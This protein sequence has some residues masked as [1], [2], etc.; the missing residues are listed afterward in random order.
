MSKHEPATLG[1]FEQLVLFAVLRLGPEGYGA[2]IQREIEQCAGRAVSLN[3]VYT[4]VDRLEAKRLV[5]TRMGEP[6]PERGGRRRKH[7]VLLPAGEAALRQ[8]YRTFKLLTEGFE[9]QLQ[10]R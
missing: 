4:T 5:R 2:S 10:G 9:R 3:A 1:D 7:V 8:T 6:T